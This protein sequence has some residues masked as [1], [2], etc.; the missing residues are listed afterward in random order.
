[1]LNGIGDGRVGDDR[2]RLLASRAAPGRRVRALGQRVTEEAPQ[3]HR[4]HHYDDRDQRNDHAD[5]D[6]ATAA[7]TTMTAQPFGQPTMS[8]PEERRR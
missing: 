5:A 2:H 7:V 1:L 3:D 6:A 8:A 4:S